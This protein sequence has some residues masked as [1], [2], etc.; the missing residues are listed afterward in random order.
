MRIF[1]EEMKEKLQ[2]ILVKNGFDE[3]R[4]EESAKNFADSSLDGVYSHGYQRFPRVID[5]IQKGY[6]DVKALPEKIAGFGAVERWDGHL[7]MGNL[8]AKMAMDRSIELAGQF[9]I[10]MVAMSNT[11]HWMRG[12]AYGWQAA[13]AGCIGICWTNTCPNMPAWGA[14]DGRIGNNP[15]VLAVPDQNGNHVVVDTAMAQYSY[16]KL[17]VCRQNGEQLPYPGGYDKEGNLTCDPGA[18][19]ETRRVVPIGYWKG[20]GLSIVLDLI[21]AVLTL[22]RTVTDLRRE[23]KAEY[24]VTQVFI[25]IR[26]EVLNQDPDKAQ[27]ILAETLQDIQ[28][29]VPVKEEHK[30]RYPGQGTLLHRQENMKNGIPVNEEIWKEI[31]SF[32]A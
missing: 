19:L 31:M 2:S 6:I 12:G 3:K 26:P 11:N 21:G 14:V 5:Y 22:G 17:N 20:S 7:G 18:I 13:E 15:F 16:G 10:G 30:V 27:Q 32:L 24:G 25:A 9:G 28:E 23:C 1:Y 4:A 29:S 8:N